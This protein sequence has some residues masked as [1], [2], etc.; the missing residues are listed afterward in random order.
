MRQV[1]F[2]IVLLT[3]LGTVYSQNYDLI[4]TTK[5]D[6]IACRIDSVTNNKIYYEMKIRNNWIHSH[7]D[8]DQLSEYKFLA[9]NKKTAK[10]KAGTSY[11]DSSIQSPGNINS[12]K[13]IQK[14]SISLETSIVMLTFSYERMFPLSDHLGIIARGGYT[15]GIAFTHSLNYLYGETALLIGGPRHFFEP[16]FSFIYDLDDFSLPD[17]ELIVRIGYHF[18][19]YNGIILRGAVLLVLDEYPVLLP[20]LSI[21]YSF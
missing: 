8:R 21:G 5:G 2:Q 11:L 20:S 6:S 16:G 17:S 1:L 14:N 10:F 19:G 3:G 18:Q 12:I 15:R 4:V 13:D 7:M 9:I